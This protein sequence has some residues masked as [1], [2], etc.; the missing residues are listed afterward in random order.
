MNKC[1]DGITYVKPALVVV[2]IICYVKIGSYG[3]HGDVG[4]KIIQIPKNIGIRY[5]INFILK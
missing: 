4:G 1:A 5:S 3:N 2:V